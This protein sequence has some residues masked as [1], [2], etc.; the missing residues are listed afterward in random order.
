MCTVVKKMGE[1]ELQ[2]LYN[3]GYKHNV[4]STLRATDF[5]LQH[6]E[7]SHNQATNCKISLK[8]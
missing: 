4:G 1:E 5:D 8:C 2:K 6:K 3:E 7:F